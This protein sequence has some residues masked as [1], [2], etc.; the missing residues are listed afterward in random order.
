MKKKPSLQGIINRAKKHPY[1]RPISSSDASILQHISA[2]TQSPSSNKKIE[3][4]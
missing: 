2:T 4:V 1:T 3:L